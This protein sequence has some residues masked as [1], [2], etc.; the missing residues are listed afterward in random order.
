VAHCIVGLALHGAWKHR[1]Y[2]KS[3]Y[4]AIAAW[5]SELSSLGVASDVFLAIDVAQYVKK[6]VATH[7]RP[8][9]KV[10]HASR[11]YDPARS[12][13]LSGVACAPGAAA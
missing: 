5:L 9:R 12:A 8:L 2:D 3:A 13:I 11:L 7:G 6:G 1:L 10:S 4:G